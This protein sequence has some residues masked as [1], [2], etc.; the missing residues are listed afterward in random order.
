MR[1]LYADS[2]AAAFTPEELGIVLRHS[3]LGE[4]VVSAPGPY[5]VVA[6]S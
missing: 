4:A 5:L 2:V 1:R 6:R 3:R